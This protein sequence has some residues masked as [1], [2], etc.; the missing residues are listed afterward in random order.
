MN[1][2]KLCLQSNFIVHEI[3]L[4]LTKAF[5]FEWRMSEREDVSPG[6]PLMR[7]G[8]KR[9]FHRAMQIRGFEHERNHSEAEKIFISLLK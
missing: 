3:N 1:L 2:F 7:N 5:R 4:C 8:P 9:K 6:T